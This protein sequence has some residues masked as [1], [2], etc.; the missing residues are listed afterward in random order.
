[1]EIKAFGRIFHAGFRKTPSDGHNSRETRTTIVTLPITTPKESFPKLNEY[2]LRRFSRSAIPHRAISLIRDGVLAQNW[3]IVP[4]KAGDKR[5]YSTMVKAIE[6]VIT[7]PNEID[8]YRSFW[9][10]IINETLIGDNGSAEIV[11]TGNSK[12]PMKLYPVNGFSLEYVEGFFDNPDYPRFC[13]V[14][15]GAH[16]EYLYDKDIIYIQHNKTVDTA[17]GLSPLEAAFRQMLALGSAQEYAESQASN[18]MPKNALN[19]GENASTEDIYKFRKYF[20]EEVYGRGETPIIGGSKGASSLAIG[21]EGDEGLFLEWQRHLITIIALA[22]SIDPKKLGQ[23]SNTDRSTVEEQNESMLNEAIR[24]YCLLLQDAIN[25]K[26]IGRLG[27]GELLRF[28]FVFEDTL[29]QKQKRQQMITDQWNTNGITL[30]EYR[31]ALG[32]PEIDSP[33]NDMCQAE[34]KSALNKKYAIQPIQSK[35]SISGSSGGF[36]GLGKNQKEDVEK[37]TN[38]EKERDK[39]KI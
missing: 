12:Q 15:E 36:N 18:A 1:M 32:R 31:E 4:A 14:T 38:G 23:G 17:F 29:D 25:Q 19:L 39:S 30:R 21:P 9:G 3:R 22:F 26:I 34:M 7:H 11:F 16:R 13:Q 5:S 6:N 2:N 28:E 33:Y 27:L 37:K 35:E 24:P 20:A 10:Q 8:D